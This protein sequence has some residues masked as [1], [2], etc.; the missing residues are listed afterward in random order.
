MYSKM[1]QAIQVLHFKEIYF[2]AKLDAIVSIT[3]IWGYATW[4]L[5]D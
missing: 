3:S 4:V 5:I 2:Y 1:S